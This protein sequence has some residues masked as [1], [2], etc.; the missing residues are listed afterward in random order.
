[1]KIAYFV[2]QYPK[3]SHSFIRREIL[4]LE[5]QGLTIERYALRGWDDATLVDPQDLAELGRTRFVLR[6]GI[7]TLLLRTLLWALGHPGRFWRNQ[8]R[9]ASRPPRA[10]APPPATATSR[11]PLH[12]RRWNFADNATASRLPP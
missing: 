11:G 12:F 9:F 8:S 7:G 4:A 2:N 5:R 1:M 6:E 10:I 3:V